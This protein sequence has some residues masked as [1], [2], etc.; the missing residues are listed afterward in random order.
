M[1]I[2]EKGRDIESAG[3]SPFGE[4][5][6]EIRLPNTDRSRHPLHLTYDNDRG[7]V[8]PEPPQIVSRISCYNLI[9]EE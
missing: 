6:A 8:E 1:E 9:G 5:G 7:T 4:M 3:C 2:V